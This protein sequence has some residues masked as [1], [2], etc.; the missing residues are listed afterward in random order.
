MNYRKMDQETRDSVLKA[1]LHE[2]KV[3]LI[4][5]Y[6]LKSTPDLY[7]ISESEN[8][9]PRIMFRHS[10]IR[11]HDLVMVLGRINSLCFA[12]VNYLRRKLDLFEPYRYDFKNGFVKTELWDSQF[13]KHKP[14]GYIFDYRELSGIDDVE[15]F[16]RLCEMLDSYEAGAGNEPADLAG[17][18]GL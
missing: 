4:E 1:E 3:K 6:R 14:S 7:W 15:E 13:M 5:K 18:G 16:R 9:H 10:F 12:K 8:T 11:K 2:D 17:K